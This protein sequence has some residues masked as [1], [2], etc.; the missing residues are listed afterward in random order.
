[1]CVCVCVCDTPAGKIVGYSIRLSGRC[2]FPFSTV[3]RTSSADTHGISSPA[4]PRRSPVTLANSLRGATE[5]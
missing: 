4:C 2:D 1:M 3:T 5:V